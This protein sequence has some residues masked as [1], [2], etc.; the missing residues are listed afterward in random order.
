MF[1]FFSKR[2]K[3]DKL[4]TP[5]AVS[6]IEFSADRD[7]VIWIDCYWN[8]DEHPMAHVM[9]ADL[10]QR[11]C[12]GSMTDEVMEFIQGQCEKT[13][14]E[15]ELKEFNENLASFHHDFVDQV[16]E[17][18]LAAIKEKTESEPVV[19]PTRVIGGDIRSGKI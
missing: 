12:S 9:L 18:T 6:K 2:N 14:K 4:D 1:N 13:G 5:E 7:G 10:I 16:M 15:K 3:A 11:V 19:K 17:E 8:T